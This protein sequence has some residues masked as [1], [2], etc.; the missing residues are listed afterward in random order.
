MTMKRYF[1]MTV[2]LSLLVGVSFVMPAHAEQ[3]KADKFG[4]V[5]LIKVFD[6]YSK[7][8]E[9]EK[10]L[11]DK[12]KI[13]LDDRKKMVDDIRKL[14]DELELLADNAKKD[15]QVAI[16]ERIK[17]LQDFDMTTRDELT[18]ERD[19]MLRNLLKEIDVTV[20]GYAKKEGFMVVFNNRF[21]IYADQS[22]D[23]TDTIIGL[24]NAPVKK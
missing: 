15:K 22:I 9:L 11:S 19:D 3:A 23:L 2:G 13:K 1:W 10:S 6:S 12:E 21:L 20:S 17:K 14:K 4:Y 18:K 24:L 7:T 8:K 16:D 5:D